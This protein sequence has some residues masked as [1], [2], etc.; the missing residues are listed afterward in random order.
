MPVAVEPRSRGEKDQ[1]TEFFLIKLS[2]NGSE[3][4]VGHR[5]GS[6]CRCERREVAG[7]TERMRKK[8]KTRSFGS[9]P[10]HPSFLVQPLLLHRETSWRR[11]HQIVQQ[12]LPTD[13]SL[14]AKFLLLCLLTPSSGAFSQVS[15]NSSST[16]QWVNSSIEPAE[17]ERRSCRL[18]QGRGC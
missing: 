10:C 9:C 4:L 15:L 3:H 1:E 5:E 14:S 11:L 8:R 17:G 7:H 18:Q 12:K 13:E 2:G 16:K 6:S